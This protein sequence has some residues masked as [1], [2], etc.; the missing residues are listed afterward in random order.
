MATQQYDNDGKVQRLESRY[1]AALTE[2]QKEQPFLHSIKRIRLLRIFER[3]HGEIEQVRCRLCKYEAQEHNRQA[4]LQ[5]SR[6]EQHERLRVNYAAQLAHL[7]LAGI[8]TNS[9]I[10]LDQLQKQ[11]G[12]ADKVQ[13]ID[14]TISVI[15][16]PLRF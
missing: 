8:S 12:N 7:S 10:V 15:L 5:A 2:L 4:D 14:K 1:G 9:P 13:C 3:C 16:L 11:H 6:R